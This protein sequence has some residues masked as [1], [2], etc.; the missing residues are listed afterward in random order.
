MGAVF[1][2]FSAWYFWVPKILGLNYNE[3]AAKI[4]FWIFFIG[5]NATFFPQHFLGL[6]GMPRRISDYPD[7]FGGWNMI[8]SIGSLV[9]VTSIFLFIYIIYIQLINDIKIPRYYSEVIQFFSDLLQI[10][11]KRTT[12][13]LEWALDSP[14]KVHPFIAL[15]LSS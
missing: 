2:L 9:S 14:P 1:A 12:E 7:A 3:F 8:S 13:S 15:P 11:L 10:M 4:H 5:V 6:Q